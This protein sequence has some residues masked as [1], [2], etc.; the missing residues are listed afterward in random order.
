ML[1]NDQPG[2]TPNL[3][4]LAGLD[5]EVKVSTLIPGGGHVQR[6]QGPQEPLLD[7]HDPWAPKRLIER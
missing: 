7:H 6:V 5:G 3:R 4:E 1:R 2:F